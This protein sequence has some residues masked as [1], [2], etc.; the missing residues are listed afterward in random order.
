MCANDFR[1]ASHS[2]HFSALPPNAN[3]ALSAAG[4]CHITPSESGTWPN[5]RTLNFFTTAP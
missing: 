2:S 3:I 5:C 1:F 4:W